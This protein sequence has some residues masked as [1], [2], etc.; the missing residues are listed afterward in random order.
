ME[1]V[2]KTINGLEWTL[3]K[4]LKALGATDVKILKRA[5]SFNGDKKL[6]Y[7]A[8][9]LLRTAMRILMPIKTVE[10]NNEE[11]LYNE[12]YKIDWS[13]YFTVKETFAI[14]GV[15]ASKVFTHS[16]YVALKSKDAIADQFRDKLGIRP[17][18]NTFDPT[19]RINVRIFNTTC[20]ISLDTSGDSL[21]KRGYRVQAV[22]APLTEVLAAGMILLTDY[23]GDSIFVDPMC[24]SGTLLIEA[25]MIAKHIPPQKFRQGF[26]FQK[27]KDYDRRLFNEVKNEAEEKIVD[28]LKYP[29]LGF[30]KDL[31]A[32][33][34]SLINLAEASLADEIEVKRKPFQRLEAPEPAEG[35]GIIVMNPPYDQRLKEFDI[36]AFYSEIGDQ[37]KQQ[38][39]GYDAY[40]IS[41]NIEALKK[42]GLRP[43]DKFVL[44][45][46]PL[47][48]KY[49]KYEMYQGSQKAKIN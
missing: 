9:Y 2:A 8:N 43:S 11:E 47:E 24:G 23:N 1:L 29:I 46:G 17:N 30:D 39:S 20:T 21:H 3:S 34:Y 33:K 14:D 42:V 49:H 7:Q 31:R 4:E 16:K 38:F 32:V 22:E 37:L 36:E 18:V 45:N 48:C 13:Q 41:S 12:I 15:T 5:V 27:W 28:K 6:M 10:V 26:G 25:G 44:N 35:K 40:I 19:L